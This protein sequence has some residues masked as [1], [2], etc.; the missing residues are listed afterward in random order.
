MLAAT[1]VTGLRKRT[2]IR[3]G[4][5][6][7]P[8]ARLPPAAGG[9]APAA[10]AAGAGAGPLGA[11]G[12]A[13][14]AFWVLDWLPLSAGSPVL[15]SAAPLPSSGFGRV[16]PQVPLYSGERY[17][18]GRCVLSAA[19]PGSLLTRPIMHLNPVHATCDFDSGI[20]THRFGTS[21]MLG[22]WPAFSF[23]QACT[24]GARSGSAGALPLA[25]RDRQ[26]GMGMAW[27]RRARTSRSAAE[28]ELLASEP[29]QEGPASS[30]RNT[31]GSTQGR[32][33]AAASFMLKSSWVD[34]RIAARPRSSSAAASPQKRERPSLAA[35]RTS[36]AGKSAPK[37]QAQM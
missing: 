24:R 5:P 15:P 33:Q 35:T 6:A 37:S 8:Q 18:A 25:Q 34:M 3:S 9:C 11:L 4:R 36:S 22:S 2:W 17:G 26:V 16:V 13:G 10:G 21:A 19:P 14:A 29:S 1:Q 30:C 27:K 12:A 7:P 32:L 20:G 31:K 23:L 28:L